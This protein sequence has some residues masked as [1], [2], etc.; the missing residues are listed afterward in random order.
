M[1]TQQGQILESLLSGN[2]ICRVNQEESFRYLKEPNNASKVE[3]QLNLLNRTLSTAAEGE[4]FFASYLTLGENER[5]VLEKQFKETT[6]NLIPLVEWLVL[7]Q[8]STGSDSPLVQGSPIR[9]NELQSTIE[10]VPALSEQL[11]K[12]STYALFNSTSKTTD[13][14]LK[15]VFKRLTELGYLVKPNPEKLIYIATGKVDYLYEVIRFIDDTE[16]LSLT[17]QAE[18][19][20]QQ[21]SLL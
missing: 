18:S 8:E 19:A 9:L 6:T 4:V 1:I 5:K 17:E 3:A 14:Q 10:D 16:A 7:V 12:I 13:G 15:Q 2:F 20:M 21:G 11:A